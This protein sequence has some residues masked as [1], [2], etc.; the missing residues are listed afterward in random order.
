MVNSGLLIVDKPRGV[1][2]H[3]VVAAARSLLHMKKVGH[4][5]TLD[6]MATGM[7]VLGFGNATRLLNVI[8]G[9]TKTYE[10]IIRF[11]Q[12][13]STD[14]AEGQITSSIDASDQLPSI[15]QVTSIIN[16]SFMGAIEQI[17]NAFSA[18]KINGKRAYDLAREGKDVDL[19]ARTITIERF[20]VLDSARTQ[21]SDG[22]PVLD[23]RVRVTCS[24]GTYIRALARDLGFCCKC[25]AHLTQ[26]RRL[27]IGNFT[28]D[29][30]RIIRASVTERTF[31]NRE[32]QRVTRNRAVLDCT[33]EQL[34][35]HVI[36]MVDAVRSTLPIVDIDQTQA[37]DL[38]F[39]R[40]IHAHAT[41]LSAAVVACS[42]D[43]VALVE[44]YKRNE[45]QPVSVFPAL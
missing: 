1:T 45:L 29:D 8:V 42:D 44:P 43:V 12:S 20:D 3:D 25:G 19:Q 36:A 33:R 35:Q 10:A 7:L 22:T 38:R 26:L 9:H 15:E 39:G 40:R 37:Q 13:T 27:N 2:S 5:G 16:E 28:V 34:P 17:P 14:D 32:G 4:A 30:P 18:I 23:V 24:A 6:P 31:T 41:Q 21:A 11:G